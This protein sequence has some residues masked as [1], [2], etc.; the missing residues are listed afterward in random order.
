MNLIEKTKIKLINSKI[1]AIKIDAKNKGRF[2]LFYTRCFN[3][4]LNECISYEKI[5]YLFDLFKKWDDVCKI[6]YDVG[7]KID[8]L[9]YNNIVLIHRTKLDLNKDELG[10]PKNNDLFDIMNNGL[11]N[12][13]HGNARGGSA[14]SD[15]PPSLRL[16]STILNGIPG[17]IN[18]LSS[19][20]DNDCIILLCFSKSFINKEGDS[21]DRKYFKYIYSREINGGYQVNSKYMYG[22]ILKKNGEFDEFYTKDEIIN[23]NKI[24]GFRK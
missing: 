10:I 12:Y 23:S 7:V 17:Y 11:I 21:V 2:S 6:R 16:T 4:K 18:L 1:D 5:K 8:N 15:S 20:K 14:F 13:G 22:A 3:E 9:A 24:G 19:F